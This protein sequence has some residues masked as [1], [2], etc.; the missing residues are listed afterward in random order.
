M[1]YAGKVVDADKVAAPALPVR[2]G[3]VALPLVAGLVEPAAWLTPVE[4]EEYLDLAGRE[5]RGP[6]PKIKP[7]HR[8]SE[9]EDPDTTD[10]EVRAGAV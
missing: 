9:A 1:T 4:R 7:C 5:L 2:A 8:I 6:P 3:R 10:V